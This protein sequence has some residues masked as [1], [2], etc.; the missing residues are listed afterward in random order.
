MSRFTDR[1]RRGGY[2]S[3]AYIIP[4][5]SISHLLHVC[6]SVSIAVIMPGPDQIPPSPNKPSAPL[7]RAFKL[8]E[9][10]QYDGTNPENPVYVSIKGTNLSCPS[11]SY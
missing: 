10:K 11:V 3:Y 2:V 1:I 9:L 4:S 7:S 5:C 6:I 8:E